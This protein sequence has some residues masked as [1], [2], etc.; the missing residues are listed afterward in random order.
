MADDFEVPARTGPPPKKK[1]PK[2]PSAPPTP[3]DTTPPGTDDQK[4]TALIDSPTSGLQQWNAYRDEITRIAG[5]TANNLIELVSVAITYIGVDPGQ[6]PDVLTTVRGLADLMNTSRRKYKTL[7]DWFDAEVQARADAGEFSQPAIDTLPSVYVGSYKAPIPKKPLTEDERIR[8]SVRREQKRKDITDPEVR[9]ARDGTILVPGDKGYKDG[10]TLTQPGSDTALR[11]SDVEQ[12][13]A[14]WREFFIFYGY[15]QV[16]DK[17]LTRIIR[18]GL[19]QYS[20]STFL[21][22]DDKSAAGKERRLKFL[23]S[24]AWKT[25]GTGYKNLWEQTYGRQGVQPDSDLIVRAIVNGWDDGTFLAE[26]RKRPD[27]VKSE[28]HKQERATMRAAYEQIYGRPDEAGRESIQ[29]ATLAGWSVEQFQQWLRA[30]PEYGRSLETRSK[31]GQFSSMVAQITGVAPTYD[32]YTQAPLLEGDPSGGTIPDDPRTE[33]RPGLAQ[34]DV[35]GRSP[36]QPKPPAPAGAP[37]DPSAPAAPL[38][39]PQRPVTRE[40]TDRARAEAE[41]RAARERA[42]NRARA[43]RR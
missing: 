23:R 17:H 31:I 21:T 13:R 15:N 4:W 35:T 11:L 20:V 32:G 19:G 6:Y 14:S 36:D 27:W 24:P 3:V 29:E 43:G 33:A 25:Y 5:E 40:Q 2:A 9:V 37:V 8:A 38:P 10:S 41:A 22:G 7:D 34:R 12:A 42:R 30:Q 1:E 18:D 16:S 26:A 39:S 28:T